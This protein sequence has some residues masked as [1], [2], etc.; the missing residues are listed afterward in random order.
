LHFGLGAETAI[1]S[2]EVRWPN[3]GR[4]LFSAEG[5]DRILELVEGKGKHVEGK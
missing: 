4:E 3:G 2:I 5:V 1:G